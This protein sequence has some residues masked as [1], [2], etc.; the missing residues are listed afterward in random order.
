MDAAVV[1]EPLISL[2]NPRGLS[3]S[4]L[5]GVSALVLAATACLDATA[6]TEHDRSAAIPIPD[7]PAV[8]SLRRERIATDLLNPR[9]ML[10][11]GR[12]LM[13]AMA[14]RGL[15][16]DSGTG[17]LVLLRDSDGDKSLDQ[18]HALLSGQP[19][20]NILH[21]VRRDEVF[22]MADIAR[23]GGDTLV[24]A[25]FFGGPSQIYEVDGTNVSLWNTVEG[26]INAITFDEKRGDWVAVS[27]SSEQVLRIFPDRPAEE[28]LL[29][30]DLPEGQDPVPGYVR[31]EPSTGKLLVSLFSGSPLGEE[32][33][34]GTEIVPGAGGI[35][36]VDP[37]DGSFEWVVSGL[38]APTDI[39][40]DDSGRIYVL[41][42]CSD[43]LDPVN[44]RAD[45]W[46]SPGHGGFKRFSGRLLRIDPVDRSVTL[47]ADG[48]D[49]PTN[50]H[51]NS[52]S[53][54]VAQGMGTPGRMIP[55]PDGDVP[56]TGFI[57]HL[58]LD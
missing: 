43:F 29:I 3:Q 50:L 53:L 56:L 10:L 42:F 9:G 24:T 33:G 7:N 26:N 11:D 48:L 23:G 14:G 41:E 32:N 31:Y 34:D 18:R 47:I 46:Q 57:E 55:G 15:E 30:P 38:T 28:I 4:A 52:D 27:S 44:T 21:I 49:G 1:W 51:V 12:T 25:A 16:E 37:D 45:M 20:R 35:I 19:S 54:L 5:Q 36:R 58:S 39:A 13:V 17:S 6:A 8:E 22:G 2:F 40:L